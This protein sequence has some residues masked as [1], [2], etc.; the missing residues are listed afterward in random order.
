MGQ[1]HGLSDHDA[2][3]VPET[4]GVFEDRCHGRRHPELRISSW[5]GL[6]RAAYSGYFVPRLSP[7]L[8][9]VPRSCLG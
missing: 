5:V 3:R 7:F 8:S 9:P 6:G 4:L 1:F 2:I